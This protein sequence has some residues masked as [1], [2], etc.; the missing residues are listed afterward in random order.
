MGCC[1]STVQSPD[2]SYPR[3]PA[4]SNQE[5]QSPLYYYQE[6]NCQV[7]PLVWHALGNHFTENYPEDEVAF[8]CLSLITTNI[9]D[10]RYY[11]LVNSELGRS[12]LQAY[13]EHSPNILPFVE[14]DPSL[15]RRITGLFLDSV[16]FA[17]DM[18]RI[19]F[20]GGESAS[21]GRVV[22][23]TKLHEAAV[24]L[25]GD[26]R[27]ALPADSGSATL[28][29]TAGHFLNGAVGLSSAEVL[30]FM[31]VRPAAESKD[32][33]PPEDGGSAHPEPRE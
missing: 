24:A 25:L 22:Y 13:D 23:D 6:T 32:T 26:I 14:G 19:H 21:A 30:A 8:R 31:Q 11:L 3:H 1:I 5:C 17:Q 2:G 15:M 4:N 28:L 12:L 27:A 9:F 29:D 33:A 16:A 10:I 7:C 20:L 18:L